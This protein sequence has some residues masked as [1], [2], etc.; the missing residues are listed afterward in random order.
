[1]TGQR[2]TTGEAV[3]GLFSRPNATGGLARAGAAADRANGKEAVASPRPTSSGAGGSRVRLGVELTDAEIAYLRGLSRPGRTGESRTLGA[4][5]V[6]TGILAAAIE[7]LEHTHIDMAGVRA[8]D[9]LEMAARARA[10]LLRVVDDRGNGT[11]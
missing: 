10:A 9:E 8:G 11:A 6:A 1:M 5:F 7:L 4:K 3:A 2:P